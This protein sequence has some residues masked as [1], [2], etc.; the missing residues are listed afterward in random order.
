MPRF[1]DT[2]ICIMGPTAVGKTAL[3]IEL[4]GHFRTEIINGDSR[5][6]YREMS[7]GTAKPN[8]DE[9]A[10]VKHHFIDHISV[11]QLYSAG[12][13]E[14]DALELLRGLFKKKHIVILCGGSGL[15][16]KALLEGLD[17]LPEAPVEIREEL[18]R[19]VIENRLEELQ[20]KLKDADPVF[21][22]SGEIQNPQRVVRA[23]EVF[24]ATGKPYSSFHNK[25]KKVRPFNIIKIILNKDRD[26]LY[27]QINN[28]VDKMMEAGLL[29]EAKALFPFKDLNA[30]KTV[31]YRE[32]F[33]YFEG[34]CDLNTAVELIKQHT[35]NYAK[36]QITWF[37]RETDAHWFDPLYTA[38]IITFIEE[39][40]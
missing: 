28:R 20:E 22:N 34:K 19:A 3:A 14:K 27:K 25:I 36:R 10:S 15:Y 23:L 11:K 31:G 39:N 32:L 18:N 35:R 8:A 30:L 2:L 24:Y 16:L 29:E 4:A 40:I 21:Y 37:K 1:P 17:D 6:F 26:Y 5:Q 12:D 7:I 38:K 13:F 9:L 33:D